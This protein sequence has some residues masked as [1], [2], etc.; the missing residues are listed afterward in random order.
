MSRLTRDGTAER[1]SRDKFS[2][3]NKDKDIFVFPLQ[4]TTSRI[5]NPTRLIHT[6]KKNQNTPGPS[7][8][9]PVM[10]EKMYF[11][12]TTDYVGSRFPFY[13]QTIIFNSNSCAVLH[14][15]T[16]HK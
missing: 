3:P 2:G 13:V 12:I 1:L 9:P 11:V 10:G 4:L 8:H 6:L 15:H 7:E 16:V 14:I 5:G